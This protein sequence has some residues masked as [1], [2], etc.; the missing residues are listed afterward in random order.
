MQTRLFHEKMRKGPAWWLTLGFCVLW[1]LLLFPSTNV[2]LP[3]PEA[4]PSNRLPQPL[5]PPS[6]SSQRSTPFKNQHPRLSPGNSTFI[7]LS[8]PEISKLTSLSVLE[9]GALQFD[10]GLGLAL[11]LTLPQVEQLNDCLHECA[12]RIRNSERAASQILEDSSG[13]NYLYLR[14]NSTAALAVDAFLQRSEAVAPGLGS[15]LANA[16][17]QSS[18]IGETAPQIIAFGADF[19]G[20]VIESWTPESFANNSPGGRLFHSWEHNDGMFS[21]ALPSRYS[22]LLDIHS[23]IGQL[24][25]SFSK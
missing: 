3:A 13:G 21:K 10:A 24:R 6:V 25:S 12:D 7:E 15:Q 9:P 23:V 20:L 5:A 14:R 18:F 16:A 11:G 1:W 2:N 8:F 4:A 19:D 22:H 17:T